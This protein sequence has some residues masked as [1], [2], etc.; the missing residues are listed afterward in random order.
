[1]LEPCFAAISKLYAESGKGQLQT[2]V[3]NARLEIEHAT[4][5]DNWNGGT[6]GHTLSFWVPPEIYVASP[7]AREKIEEELAR[8]INDAKGVAN[9]YV[10]RVHLK[11]ELP[12]G[13]DWRQQS[14]LLQRGTRVVAEPALDRIWDKGF[15][16]LFLSHK[17]QDAKQTSD[18]KEKL[19]RFGVSAF[20]AHRDIAPTQ[21]WQIEIENALASMDGFVALMTEGFH[22]SDWTDQEVG[23]A[24]ARNVPMIAVRLGRDPYGFIGKF[25]ALRCGWESA[26]KEVVRL[27]IN[28]PKMRASFIVALKSC[29]SFDQANLLAAI[30]GDIR[31]PESRWVDEVVEAHNANSELRG[32]FGFNGIKPSY[33][34]PGLKHFVKEWTGSEYVT[35]ADGSLAPF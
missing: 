13:S 27:L 33:Y 5:Y 3:V 25:Q 29:R 10:A 14:G 21:E 4:D 34:G 1:M 23:Y 11:M 6:V 35:E 12:A 2:L 15:F 31:A 26:A 19:S 9:E 20:V 22:E 28:H 16:R 7:R 30:F 32:S 24:L 17:S 18:L 8:D